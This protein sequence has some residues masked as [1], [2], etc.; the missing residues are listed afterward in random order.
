M[1]LICLRCMKRGGVSILLDGAPRFVCAQ[2]QQEYTV[3]EA[4]K[5][6]EDINQN[7]VKALAWVNQAPGTSEIKK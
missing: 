5:T 6:V 3:A 1:N 2:C 4:Q 7:W